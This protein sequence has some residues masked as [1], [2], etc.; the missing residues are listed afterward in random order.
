[1]QVLGSTWPFTDWLVRAVFGVA[2]GGLLAWFWGTGAVYHHAIC[3]GKR[4]PPWLK[5]I[6]VKPSGKPMFGLRY[7]HLIPKTISVLLLVGTLI[8]YLFVARPRMSVETPNAFLIVT[9]FPTYVLMTW[10]IIVWLLE[11]FLRH[12]PVSACDKRNDEGP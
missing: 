3:L 1:M 7:A 8:G 9:T 4:V 5:L 6:T 10:V 2:V 12:I 11:R